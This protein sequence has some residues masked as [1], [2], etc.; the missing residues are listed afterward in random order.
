MKSQ[1]HAFRRAAAALVVAAA[2][3]ALAAAPAPSNA[4]QIEGNSTTPFVGDA[5]TSTNGAWSG[6]PTS[7][8][9]QWRRCDALGDR[10]NCAAITGAT[11][12]KYTVQKADVGHT[13]SVVVTAKNADGT[14]SQDSKGTGI[15]SDTVAPKLY[16]RPTISGDASVGSTLTGTTG[17][18][19]G[20]TSIAL[21]WQQCDA[22][23][24][25][26]VAISG[27]NGRTYGVRTLD[28]GHTLRL[29]VTASNKYGSTQ[30]TSAVS[31]VVT[32][33]PGQ[34]TTTV[35][36]S[37]VA[38]NRAPSI[39]F[40]SLKRVGTRLYIRFRVCD[41]RYGKI[42]V[43]ERTQKARQLPYARK[44]TVRTTCATYARHWTMLKRFH[45]SHG[46]VVVTLRAMDSSGAL[47][48][49]VSR[50]VRV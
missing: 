25:A 13:L 17:T 28:V 5:L 35:V 27:A 43:T 29:Q 38:G 21:Q 47:S 8:T 22:T 32:A 20:A 40:L 26:C 14:A 50:S 16:A 30:A 10:R 11:A 1:Q 9:Y 3:G 36:T 15:V 12:A 39:R 34:T 31:D 19:A 18:W 33:M 45:S 23:G 44:F 4:P 6:S 49:L 24:T 2:S 37:T 46:R 41:D 48:R 42:T 7:F